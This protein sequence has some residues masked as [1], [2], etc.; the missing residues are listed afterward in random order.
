MN[1][2]GESIVSSIFGGIEGEWAKPLG[3]K[4]KI[5]WFSGPQ[6]SK[7]GKCPGRTKYARAPPQ[8]RKQDV[9]GRCV[10]EDRCNKCSLKEGFCVKRHKSVRGLVQGLLVPRYFVKLAVRPALRPG[11]SLRFARSW[12]EGT[13]GRDPQIVN[14]VREAGPMVTT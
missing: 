3:Q 10:C 11:A 4:L 14:P 8:T 6:N 5:G 7:M 9:A 13:L 1:L 12:C 2:S